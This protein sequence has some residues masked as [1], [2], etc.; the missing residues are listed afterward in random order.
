MNKLDETIKNMISESNPA[1]D[2]ILGD[3][4][5]IDFVQKVICSNNVENNATM[6]VDDTFLNSVNFKIRFNH[7]YRYYYNRLLK[8]CAENDLTIIS[9]HPATL[10]TIVRVTAD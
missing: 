5:L 3:N 10:E 8:F 7:D 2:K 6:F 4:I 9:T 1:V